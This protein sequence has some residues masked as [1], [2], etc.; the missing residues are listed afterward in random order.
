MRA[1]VSTITDRE[2]T[3]QRYLEM[4]ET[5][6]QVESLLSRLQANPW[7]P[8]SS[9]GLDS[10]RLAEENIG[11]LHYEYP[12]HQWQ[13]EGQIRSRLA[14]IL[15]LEILGVHPDHAARVWHA[16]FRGETPFRKARDRQD[17]PDAYIAQAV[18]DEAEAAPYDEK[19]YFISSDKRL[20]LLE[21]HRRLVVLDELDGFFLREELIQ[22]VRPP[23]EESRIS[24]SA[25]LS[26]KCISTIHDMINK[27]T[28]D[29][30]DEHDW[31]PG[32]RDI[33]P[34]MWKKI[35]ELSIDEKRIEP[36]GGGW[37]SLP[38]HAFQDVLVEEDRINK[39]VADIEADLCKIRRC[40]LYGKV[41]VQLSFEGAG[42]NQAGIKNIVLES[43]TP[44]EEYDYE[45]A[46]ERCHLI[47]KREEADW[48]DV[49]MK[50]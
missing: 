16:Y 3:S 14:H 20:R 6:Q 37:F 30:Y 48:L 31:Y 44:E 8:V 12:W 49:V 21:I 43:I 38:F 41:G 26:D 46:R 35:E 32:S 4:E 27:R 39:E 9:L 45:N 47:A 28:V 33:A 5:V 50:W 40:K 18:I 25:L 29:V 17:I 42:Q 2:W 15:P 36:W 10:L 34:V 13:S 24:L 23:S 1:C 22:R 11:R 19:V 7:F